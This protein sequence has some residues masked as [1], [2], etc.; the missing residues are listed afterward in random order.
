MRHTFIIAEAGVNHNGDLDKALRLVD[1]AA[2]AGADCVK[3]QTFRAGDLASGH[4]PKAGYQKATTEASESQRDML[5]R[6]ELPHAWHGKLLARCQARGVVFLSTPFD[7]A[8]LAFLVEELNLALIKLGSGE[9]TNAPLLYAAGQSGRNLVLSTGMGTLEEVRAALAAIA[10]GQLNRPPSRAAFA[11]IAAGEAGRRTLAER[12]TLLHCVTAYP[13]P[14]ED[15]NLR[16]MATLGEAFGLP[17]GYSDHTLG[18]AV[19]VAA[20]ALGAEVIEKHLTLD[21]TLPGPDH[22]AS[23]EPGEFARMVADI[24]SVATALGDGVKIPRP[25]ELNNV[26][27][28][29]KSLVA[30]RA[31]KA[32][33]LFA[34]DNVTAKRPGSGRS[35]FDYWELIGQAA[36][37]DLSEDEPIP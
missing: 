1:A 22:R 14:P 9:L 18:T 35:P 23:L 16:A 32:G 15:C 28:A 21:S 6:L 34:A 33:E 4:A 8:S 10:A 17:I 13:S 29:R 24:R 19:A 11:A 30:A 5:R 3:F 25:S 36:G 12:V 7:L 37:R 27:V 26:R 31:I 2:D 20:A